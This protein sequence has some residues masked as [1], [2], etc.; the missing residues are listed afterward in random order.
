MHVSRF[1]MLG[2]AAVVAA[3]VAV[4]V[5]STAGGAVKAKAGCPSSDTTVAVVTHFQ[6]PF[7][8]AFIDGGKQAAKE[9]GV[10]LTSASPQAIDPPTQVKIFNDVVATGVKGAVV[11]AYPAD[12]WVRPINDAVSK[13]LVVSTVDV[14]SPKSKELVMAA[15]KQYDL[16]YTMG[17]EAAK[18]LGA[19]AKGAFV[20]GLCVPGLDVIVNRVKGFTDAMKKLQPGVTV[21]APADVTTDPGKNYAA[22]GQLISQNPNALGFIGTCDVDPPNLMRLRQQKHGKWMIAAINVAPDTLQGVKNGTVAVL[23]GSQPFM[24]GYVAMRTVLM[25]LAGVNVKRGWIDTGS[26]VVTKGNVDK[27]IARENSFKTGTTGARAYYSSRINTIFKDVN[28][29]VKP[30]SQYLALPK[31]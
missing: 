20:T 4:A 5:G 9:C 3:A 28:A 6:S 7:T 11:V 22:W 23:I 13:G 1:R 12:V 17:V 30:F 24:Q 8:Q 21:S 29:S 31:S 16:G 27:I 15:P 26:E 18:Q 10:K 2:I 19:G 14:A 25:K